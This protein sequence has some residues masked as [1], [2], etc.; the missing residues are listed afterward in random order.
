MLPR[1]RITSLVLTSFF[2][3][4][5]WFLYSRLQS[6][7]IRTV[8]ETVKSKPQDARLVPETPLQKTIPAQESE[9]SISDLKAAPKPESGSTQSG[10]DT[11]APS[12]P[13]IPAPKDKPEHVSPEIIT[14]Q[15][16]P[17]K[18]EPGSKLVPGNKSSASGSGSTS[19]LAGEEGSSKA[20][21]GSKSVKVDNSSPPSSSNLSAGGKESTKDS[22]SKEAAGDKGST[23][24]TGS[25]S[26]D[27]DSTS[28]K[29]YGSKGSVG[30]NSAK[31]YLGSKMSAGDESSKTESGSK[32]SGGEK[33]TLKGSGSKSS[34]GDL[35]SKGSGYKSLDEDSTLKAGSGSKSSDGDLA[36]KGSASKSLDEG[37]TLKT[38]SGYKSSDG[39]L[40]LNKESG[41]VLPEGDSTSPFGKGQY[42]FGDREFEEQHPVDSLQSFS[43]GL[44]LNLPRLQYDFPTETKDAQ[45]KRLER[46]AAI[47][48][49]FEHSWQGYK[50]HAW[51]KDELKPLD[52][53][54]HQSF[55]GWGATLVDSLDTLWIMG[56]KEEFESA[57]E[58]AVKIKFHTSQMEELN[59]FETT[60][61]YLGGFLGAY[62]ISEG[63]YPTLLQKATEAGDFLYCAFDT[64]NRMPVTRWKWKEALEGGRQEAGQNTLIAEIG[65]LTLEFTRLSQLTGN[66][67][68][69]DAI[70]RIMEK[71]DKNQGGTKLPGLWPTV[72]NAKRMTFSDTGFTLGGMA[73][74]LYE[75]LPKQ[76]MLLGGRDEKDEPPSYKKMYEFAITAAM[77]HVFFQPMVPDDADILISG[78]AEVNPT[79]K[80]TK[81]IG[82]GQHLGCYAG[83]MVGIG[84]KIFE[85]PEH[86]NMARKLVDGCIWAYDHMPTG[87]MPEIFEMVPCEMNADNCTWN[88]TKYR[89]AVLRTARGRRQDSDPGIT[90][91]EKAIDLTIKE[92]NLQPG[93]VDLPSKMYTLRPEA[94]ESVFIHYRLTGEKDLPE[95][96]WRMFNAIENA[97]RTDYGAA[98]ITDV[99]AKEPEMMNSM[100][101]FWLAETLKYFY[102]IFSEPN[103]LNLDDFV[104]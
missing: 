87:I 76:Y 5:I 21:P 99:T 82:R 72:V 19:K 57:V 85:Q 36:S 51:T 40:T 48:D 20:E 42:T 75:Y 7:A 26:I 86:M 52:G 71:F 100:E 78:D 67:K 1:K 45:T 92:L 49:S 46:L 53:E 34:D 8:G 96:A 89:E 58:E 77:N 11:K 80:E 98:A 84:A 56:M 16:P 25:G 22:G 29:E 54:S 61:R 15:R 69:F 2:L 33:H 9:A 27:G 62:D 55:G 91:T 14:D 101:S 41:S 13:D 4:A 18:P 102:A 3:F 70:T 88:E 50:I 30:E 23:K 12:L 10:G 65:S 73:D 31:K 37:S 44:P 94:I 68:Y 32:L 93:F 24:G 59:I 38:G 47:R 79:K 6:P 103:V 104:L 39:D 66:M 64:P 97:T 63:K 90:D 83:G 74:S 60:I 43:K 95:V 17:P 35:A 81:T 28:K